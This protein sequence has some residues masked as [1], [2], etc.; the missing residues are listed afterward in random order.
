MVNLEH[1]KAII[2]T[3]FMLVVNPE[4]DSSIK[5]ISALKERL[6]SPTHAMGKSMQSMGDL[7]KAAGKEGAASSAGGGGGGVGAPRLDMNL[8]FELRALEICL[9]EVGWEHW[10]RWDGQ[11][12]SWLRRFAPWNPILPA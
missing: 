2:T 5:F 12:S 1:I 11:A 10:K 3:K 8:P 6:A 9:D 4:E 7:Q